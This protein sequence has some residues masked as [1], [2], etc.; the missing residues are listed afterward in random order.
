MGVPR[1]VTRALAGVL[2][3]PVVLVAACGGGDTSIADPPISPHPTTSSPTQQPHRES[4]EH[5]IRRFATV[6]RRMEN[7]GQIGAYLKLTRTCNECR[8]LA[9]QV[10]GFYGSGGYI[11]WGG[12]E[13][14]AIHPYSSGDK[15]NSYAVR[16]NSAS[17]RY[18]ES[19]TGPVKHLAGGPATEILS[20]KW[21]D[22][23]WVVSGRARLSS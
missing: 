23:S 21:L 8:D 10:R 9:E 22:S 6:E 20:I 13:I 11:H 12:W 15:P 16:V 2:A 4:P 14:Q 7:T 19:G 17:T 3:A 1:S 18:R 5:F